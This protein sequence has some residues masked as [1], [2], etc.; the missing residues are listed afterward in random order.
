MEAS[1]EHD[2][3]KC[4]SKN[5]YN[6]QNFGSSAKTAQCMSCI[7]NPEV[8]TKVG[9]NINTSSSKAMYSF[10]H[11]E[12]FKYKES[13]QNFYYNL[14]S[15][16]GKRAASIGYGT[17]LDPTRPN[18]SGRSDNIYNIP[19]EFELTK[20]Y[21]GSPKYSFGMGRDVCRV[22][23]AKKEEHTPSP[24]TYNPYKPFGDNA[25][26]FSMSFRY[27]KESHKGGMPGPG[28]YANYDQLNTLGKYGSAV[29][30]NSI[31]NKFSNAQ[32][33]NY[34][35]GRTPGVGAYNL[36]SMIKGNGVCFDSRYKSY[37][38]RTMG[39]R[40][41]DFGGK[42]TITPGPGAYDFFSDFEGFNKEN[43]IKKCP[44]RIE[45]EQNRNAKTENNQ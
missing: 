18:K 45:R 7:V 6:S 26:K 38:G 8:M 24:F 15:V 9:V 34:N 36:E 22:P 29:L 10:P 33:F 2:C 13:N 12:R 21:N 20:K 16:M 14:P 11:A 41:G 43:I 1:K 23:K 5:N 25:L 27:N 40:L 35:Y 30:K 37:K 42:N 39:S 31:Q 44:K 4:S 28:N 32:R 17:K 3:D 19:R